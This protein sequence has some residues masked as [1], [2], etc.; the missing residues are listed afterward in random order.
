MEKYALG[1]RFFVTTRGYLGIGPANAHMG[2]YVAI[3]I[4]SQVPYILRGCKEN[5]YRVVGETYVSGIM[6]GEAVDL[7]VKEEQA[8]DR[9]NLV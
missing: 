8:L 7:L 1:R 4:S 6:N 2:D 9:I 3:L 5:G